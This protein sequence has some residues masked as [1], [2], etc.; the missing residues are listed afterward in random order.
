MGQSLFLYVGS[1]QCS[2]FLDAI[3]GHRLELPFT[4]AI[5]YGMRRSEILG[6]KWS[7]IRD[8]R[9]YVEH[10]VS[11]MKTTQAKDRAKTEAGYRSY[12]L[13]PEI[14]AKLEKIRK[15]QAGVAKKM[16]DTFFG[17]KPT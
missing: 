3:S 1:D 9:I 14:E 17:T 2:D 11:K 4:F 8:R 15:E 12:P 16:S 7:A 5:Y 13:T 6:L 10:T